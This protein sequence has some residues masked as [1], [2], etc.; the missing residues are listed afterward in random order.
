MLPYGLRRSQCVSTFADAL[1]KT[2]VFHSHLLVQA[3]ALSQETAYGYN[4]MDGNVLHKENLISPE[5]LL[6]SLAGSNLKPVLV[7]NKSF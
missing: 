1:I 6:S 7:Q 2:K 4:N 5:P 3:L